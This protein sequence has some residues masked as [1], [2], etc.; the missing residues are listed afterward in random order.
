VGKGGGY[1]LSEGVLKRKYVPMDLQADQECQILAQI[2]IPKLY[3]E[4]ILQLAHND[5]FAGHQGVKKTFETVVK[6]FH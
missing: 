4:Q 3:Q 6:Y 5:S 1:Y 2:V